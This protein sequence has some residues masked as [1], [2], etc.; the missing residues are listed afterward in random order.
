MIFFENIYFKEKEANVKLTLKVVW[1]CC[2]SKEL[3]SIA[4][5]NWKR[6]IN[7]NEYRIFSSAVNV[8]SAAT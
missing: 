5:G 4:N 2:H 3:H 8:K 1:Y 6:H 7:Q